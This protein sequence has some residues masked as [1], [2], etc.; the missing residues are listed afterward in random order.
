MAPPWDEQTLVYVDDEYD[1]ANDNRFAVYVRQN[2]DRFRDTWSEDPAP[3]EDPVRFA[4]AAFDVASMPVMQPGYVR[5]RP[6]L[7][8][9]HLRRDDWDGTL[10][11]DVGV[12]LRHHHLKGSRLPYEWRDWEAVRF[13]NGDYRTLQEPS[14]EEGVSKA[15][16]TYSVVRVPGRDWKGL[17]KPTAYEGRTLVEEARR[18]VAVL[19]DHINR[20]A[21]PMVASLLSGA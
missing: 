19:A 9:V 13:Q 14:G 15:V 20:E 4:L 5:E 7:H 6:D 3:H 1:R 18:A 17:V 8:G 10:F 21:G 12:P 11:V 2:L 16:L